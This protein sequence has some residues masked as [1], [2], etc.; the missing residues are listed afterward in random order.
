MKESRLWAS[1][2]IALYRPWVQWNAPIRT[3]R[4]LSPRWCYVEEL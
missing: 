2:W 3:A 1:V 4:S